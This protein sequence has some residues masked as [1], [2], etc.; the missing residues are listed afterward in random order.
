M[1]NSDTQSQS[2]KIVVENKKAREQ[3]GYVLFV[4]E[5]PCLKE[6]GLIHQLSLLSRIH[7]RPIEVARVM[8]PVIGSGDGL[9]CR[10]RDSS[11]GRS[12][13]RLDGPAKQEWAALHWPCLYCI[14]HLC[15]R[16]HLQLSSFRQS[17]ARDLARQ[18]ANRIDSLLW[19]GSMGFPFLR[20]PR[21]QKSNALPLRQP[22]VSSEN[23][24]F[25]RYNSARPASVGNSSRLCASCY[26][27]LTLHFFVRY[28]VLC[29]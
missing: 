13:H 6:F 29:Y 9:L 14:L 3:G 27:N 1:L 12:I 28:G 26:S 15:H 25:T 23:W 10:D 4:A 7:A 17:S 20:K 2:I 5:P 18:P 16:P 21:R 8:I 19:G 11:Q 22:D 24:N